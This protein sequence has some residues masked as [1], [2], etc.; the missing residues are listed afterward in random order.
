MLENT[1]PLAPRDIDQLPG[2]AAWPLLGNLPQLRPLRIHQDV[3]AWSR[4]YGPLF[5][6]R[7]GRTDIVV[8]A[9][10]ALVGAALRD[11]PDGFRRPAITSAVGE[12]MGGRPG[13][14][15][16]EGA[17]WREQRRMV[18]AALAPHAVKAYF[19]ALVAVTLR[20]RAHWR[21][22][23]AEGRAIDLTD[24][25]KRFSVDVVAGLAFGTDVNTINGGEDV[26]QRHLDVILPAVARR[27]IALFPYWRYLRLPRDRQLDASVAALNGAIDALIASAR[28]KLVAEPARRARPAHLLDAMICAADEGGGIDD[29]VIAGNVMTMLLA[30]EDTTS[31]TLAW[32]LY[33]LR[34]NPAALRAARDEVARVAPDPAAFTIE[35]MDGLDYLD[36]CARE[37]MRLKPVAPFLPLE[38]LRETVIGDVRIPK[39]GLVWCVM[40]HDSVDETHV[41]RA[42]AFEPERW[43]RGGEGAIGKHLSMPFGAGVRTCPGRYLA[44]LEI[45]L[46][47]AMLLGGFEI[48]SID[49]VDGGEPEE[50]MGFTMSPIGLRMHLGRTDAR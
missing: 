1:A 49:T 28:A 2:P 33:L 27:T 16:A 24:D 46:A 35:Q 12:E 48:A 17:A 25:L 20:L 47:A 14:F 10:H 37:A 42:D 32:M 36:A 43:L 15:V 5:R 41:P 4:V 30:G 29:S 21:R 50:L 44:L 18:M 9:S 45:K 26:I 34:Q 8:L 6:V 11:R 31:H 13:V 7:F 38:A 40:R 22:A 19:P 39:G 3:E 23:A